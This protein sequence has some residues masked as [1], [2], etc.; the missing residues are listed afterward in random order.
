[1]CIPSDNGGDEEL[2][3]IGVLASVGHGHKTRAG[4]LLPSA[5]PLAAATVNIRG[6]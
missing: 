2:R 6:A 5:Q 4:V 1:M 3:A